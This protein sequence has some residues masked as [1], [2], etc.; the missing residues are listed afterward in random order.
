MV[1][2]AETALPAARLGPPAAWAG[3]IDTTVVMKPIARAPA[4]SHRRT[5]CLVLIAFLCLLD[6]CL[7]EERPGR[8]RVG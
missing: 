6:R 8:G 3:T 1:L 2:L 5:D 4:S 7:R